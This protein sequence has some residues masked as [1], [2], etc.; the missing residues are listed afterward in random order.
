M[1]DKLMTTHNALGTASPQFTQGWRK[2]T[3]AKTTLIALTARRERLQ[4]LICS[5]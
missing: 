5:G 2:F 1:A 3:H 4:P